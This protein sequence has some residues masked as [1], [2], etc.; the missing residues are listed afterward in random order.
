M[1]RRPARPPGCCGIVAPCVG[2]WIETWEHRVG[3]NDAALGS[4]P[5]WVRGLKHG[6]SGTHHAIG[7]VAPCVGA[8]IETRCWRGRC[9]CAGVAPCVGAWI[10]TRHQRWDG[11]GRIVAPCVGAWIETPPWLQC[12]MD[13]WSH[14]AWV[15][16]L[17]QVCGR[18]PDRRLV[19]HP[20]WVRGLKQHALLTAQER[21]E[22]RTL[23]GCVD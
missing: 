9:S 5:A 3:G 4:H 18:V 15:R 20:A 12:V 2:A 16:G 1:K 11:M 23:R 14:P 17:K 22:G 7:L 13:L 21:A 19:S 8:W 10:E 6:G